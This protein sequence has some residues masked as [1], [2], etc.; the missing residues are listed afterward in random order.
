[1][2]R[3]Y[4]ILTV[5]ILVLF[6]FCISC[7]EDGP[8]NVSVDGALV[9]TGLEVDQDYR[10]VSTRTDFTAGQ[11]FYFY[12]FNNQPF[13]SDR[14]TVQLVDGRNEKVLAEHTYEV[15]PLD[16]SLTDGIYFDNTGTYYITVRIDGIVRASREVTIK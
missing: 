2:I 4:S 6:L 7:S 9:E 10:I 11:D 3:R 13:G 14:L 1:M 15:D 12:F 16:E 8:V 5:I